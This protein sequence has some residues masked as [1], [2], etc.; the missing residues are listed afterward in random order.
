MGWPLSKYFRRA[1]TD[2]SLKISGDFTSG[3]GM[4]EHQR[5]TWL[6]SMPACA[7]AMVSSL[8]KQYHLPM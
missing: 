7:E 5:K 4:T 6:R 8:I 2:G 1:G 3:R